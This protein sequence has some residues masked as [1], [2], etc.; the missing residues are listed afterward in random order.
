[1]FV[2]VMTNDNESGYDDYHHHHHDIVG[3]DSGYNE[4]NP[5]GEENDYDNN[6]GDNDND[7]GDN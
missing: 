7:N 4:I 2:M 5:D 6:N 1:M 3:N